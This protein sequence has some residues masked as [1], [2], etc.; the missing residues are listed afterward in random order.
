MS[1][2]SKAV[3]ASHRSLKQPQLTQC[4]QNRNPLLPSP[5]MLG[6]R[7][8]VAPTLMSLKVSRNL[9]LLPQPP[10]S[11]KIR[12]PPRR[13]SRK[14]LLP[15]KS[16]KM[17]Q[18][19]SLLSPRK[20]LRRRRLSKIVTLKRRPRRKLH[21]S[22]RK[23]MTLARRPSLRLLPRKRSGKSWVNWLVRRNLPLRR[24]LRQ[25]QLRRRP[26]LTPSSRRRPPKKPI[27][28]RLNRISPRR[29]PMR[30][31]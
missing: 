16:A 26:K 20:R 24:R 11:P 21:A 17:R 3:S 25:I 14:R 15:P 19:A 13:K 7:P 4:Q 12:L 23:K 1:A 31:S 22:R 28:R 6:V 29:R 2:R 10:T 27:R 9:V 18:I 8:M 5:P 30:M